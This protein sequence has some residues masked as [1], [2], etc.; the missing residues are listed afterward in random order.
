MVRD[1][2]RRGW[3]GDG[4]SGSAGSRSPGRKRSAAP[5][6]A[7][8]VMED[9]RQHEGR[10]EDDYIGDRHRENDDHQ[11]PRFHRR[12]QHLAEMKPERRRRIEE[13]IKM[14]D[15]VEPPQGGSRGWRDATGRSHRSRRTRS[16]ASPVHPDHQ[17]GAI[18]GPIPAS[19]DSGTT[20]RGESTALTAAND[21]FLTNLRARSPSEA[22]CAAASGRRRNPFEDQ[23]RERKAGNDA[24]L[25]LD[26]QEIAIHAPIL[27][28]NWRVASR[29]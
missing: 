23:H 16:R 18:R 25:R 22:R 11:R 12:Q 21:M 29:E 14:M 17:T 1:P 9:R 6:G 5:A 3:H 10:L 8:G 15:R 19:P 24:A 20:T 28:A 2:Y 13:F 27:S 4:P 7:G 26:K